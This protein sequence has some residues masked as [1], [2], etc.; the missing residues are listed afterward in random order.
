MLD[1][2]VAKNDEETA[3]RIINGEAVVVNLKENTFHTL[4]PVATFI[5]EQADGQIKAK[6]MIER[7]C[8]EF[9][10]DWETAEKDCLEF[11]GKL[12]SKG[13]VVLSQNPV[14]G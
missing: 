9:E 7:I 6:Q 12:V 14:E 2:Y 11:L 5:W 3:Y 8:R 13:L 1:Q 4:N 10:V